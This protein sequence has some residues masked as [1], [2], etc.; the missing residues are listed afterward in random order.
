M[1]EPRIDRS[2]TALRVHLGYLAVLVVVAGAARMT[3]ALRAEAPAR[4]AFRYIEAARVFQSH[5]IGEAWRR[6]DVHPLYPMTLLAAKTSFTTVTGLEG[7]YAWWRAAQCWSVICSLTFLCLAYLVGVR[8]WRPRIAFWGCLAV[9]LV[10]RQ[11]GYAADVL[12]DNLMAVA[13]MGSLLCMT[14]AWE[15]PRAWSIV[16]A[17][18][19]AGLAY[20]T[21]I[22]ALLLP[23]VF[24]GAW[25]VRQLRPAWRVAWSASLAT[26]VGFALTYAAVVGLYALTIGS[27]SP[28]LIARDLLG[29]RLPTTSLAPTPMATVTES[30]HGSTVTESKSELDSRSEFGPGAEAEVPTPLSQRPDPA[31]AAATIVD[32]PYVTREGYDERTIARSIVCLFREVGE[33]LRVWLLAFA[34][35]ALVDHRRTATRMPM[36]LLLFFAVIGFAAMLLL[37]QRTGG[38][39]AGRYALPLMP[40]LAMYAMTGIEALLGRIDAG[41]KWLRGRVETID[42]RRVRLVGGVS[43]AALALTLSAPGLLRPLH[44]KRQGHLAAAEW[45]RHHSSAS[46]LV[47]DL[48]DSTAFF[49][50]R[51]NWR[52]PASVSAPMPIRFAVIDPS[53]VYRRDRVTF[54]LVERIVDEGRLVACFAEGL[55]SEEVGIYIY[56]PCGAVSA[57]PGGVPLR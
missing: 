16:G 2:R 27:L 43:C 54:D 14:H 35:V 56:E 52:P 3:V 8:M 51:S 30:S 42:R 53:M 1:A 57:A 50:E 23:A 41:V 36:G 22:G 39:V 15:R 4:D 38:Y 28:R 9:S 34:L 47:F 10:P 20:W 45:L 33:E 13:W 31:T 44:G 5:S 12:S 11:A 7:P 37:L 26:A 6:I 46:D 17:A 29:M 18:V 55:G 40:L 48:G 21:H 25:L 24:G 32:R 19:F 49:A